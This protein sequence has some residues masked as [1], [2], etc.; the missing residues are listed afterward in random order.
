M[1]PTLS[2][3]LSSIPPL[4]PIVP[5]LSLIVSTDTLAELV[6]ETIG[7]IAGSGG[8]EVQHL[9]DSHFILYS[10]RQTMYSLIL[11]QGNLFKE[12]LDG[13]RNMTL[14][15]LI[16]YLAFLSTT[17]WCWKDLSYKKSIQK[18]K[19]THAISPNMVK[20]IEM[21]LFIVVMILFQDVDNATG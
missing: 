9:L 15:E 20:R 2:S 21:F 4:S 12:L 3:F 10:L 5:P 6:T 13:F 19:E 16:Y 7:N 17:Y 8:I 14:T 18:I 1:F 11:N